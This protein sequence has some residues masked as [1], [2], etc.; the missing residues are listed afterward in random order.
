MANAGRILIMPKG[1]Y[2]ASVTYEML[3]LVNHNGVSWLAKKTVTGIEPSEGEY[4][5]PLLG[6]S[7]A[8]DLNT[9]AEGKVLDARQGKVIGDKLNQVCELTDIAFTDGFHGRK[10]GRQVTLFFEGYQV[11]DLGESGNGGNVGSVFAPM[12]DVVFPLVI[13]NVGICVGLINTA[14]YF[15]LYNADQTQYI[16]GSVSGTV[17]YMTS[18][19]NVE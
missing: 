16:S 9:E 14:G 6:I 5:H 11:S 15:T 2:D 8:N 13:P 17:S 1:N 19:P 12:H 10:I 3:D 4:W 18:E 7:I